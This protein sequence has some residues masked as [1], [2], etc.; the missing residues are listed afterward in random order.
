VTV[1]RLHD[2]DEIAL[3]TCPVRK[4]VGDDELRMLEYNDTISGPILH[5][6]GHAG[7]PL[8]FANQDRFAAYNGTAPVEWSS[9]NPKKPTHRLSRR[10]NHT[11]K[12]RAP[13]RRGDS[14]PPRSSGRAFYDRKR[15]EGHTTKTATVH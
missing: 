2:G 9:G 8:R 7:N 5:L 11:M 3:R 1:V 6:I 14:A 4:R 13:H 15:A 12:P 10:G